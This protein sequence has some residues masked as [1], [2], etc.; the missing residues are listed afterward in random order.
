[1]TQGG[2]PLPGQT[3]DV[4]VKS[5]VALVTG[6]VAYLVTNFTNQPQSW[7]L[8]L[9][10]VIGGVILLAQFL[11]DFEKRLQAVDGSLARH[12][13]AMTA[14]VERRF[15][16]IANVVELFNLVET[17]A[18]RTDVITQFLRNAVEID[19][20]SPLLYDLAHAEIARMSRFLAELGHGTATYFGEDR[21][22]LLTLTRCVR[23]SIDATS[24]PGVDAGNHGATDGFWQ[25]DLGNRYLELQKA[26][27]GRNVRIRRIF[28]LEE[29]Q[30]AED[31]AFLRTCRQQTELGIEVKVLSAHSVPGTLRSK[32]FD[33][34]LFDGLISYESTPAT[35]ISHSSGRPAIVNTRLVLRPDVLTEN[36]ANFETLWRSAKTIEIPGEATA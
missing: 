29:T 28:V 36:I 7:S 25:S 19:E 10:V 21:D 18:I 11:V 27:I 4:V 23:S 8:L 24:M 26:A 20:T 14:V 35:H 34:V 9:S 32:L 31:L 30:S 15:A 17:S 33:F 13:A 16:E 5:V 22:W 12:G 6:G 1:M 3:S 2:R